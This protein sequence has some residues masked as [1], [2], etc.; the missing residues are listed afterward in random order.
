[1][2]AVGC[3]RTE[4]TDMSV[5]SDLAHVVFEHDRFGIVRRSAIGPCG[6]LGTGRT[7]G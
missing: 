1:V 3:Q 2:R 6:T 7:W 5:I 4:S